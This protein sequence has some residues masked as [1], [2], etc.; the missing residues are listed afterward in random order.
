MENRVTDNFNFLNTFLQTGFSTLYTIFII[1]KET[2]I[3]NEKKTS[4]MNSE[5]PKRE[6]NTNIYKPKNKIFILFL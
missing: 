3:N 2:I 1:R 4:K 5:P 6:S